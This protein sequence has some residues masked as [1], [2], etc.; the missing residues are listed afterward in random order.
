M[1]Q[2]WNRCSNRQWLSPRPE[3]LYIH[4]CLKAFSTSRSGQPCCC[5]NTFQMLFPLE[6]D[7]QLLS[8][9]VCSGG[10]WGGWSEALTV[11]WKENYHNRA[12]EMSW[13]TNLVLQDDSC[14]VQMSTNVM[15]FF[16]CESENCDAKL[17]IP[18]NRESYR[19]RN[20]CQ[21]THIVMFSTK[22]LFFKLSC[23]CSFNVTGQILFGNFCH[24]GRG[25]VVHLFFIHCNS[26]LSHPLQL[27]T[28]SR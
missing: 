4:S 18:T 21:N 17:I 3:L 23:Q 8:V 25:L 11:E 12:G 10:N 22:L 2:T 19:S 14:L 1:H 24:E 7:Y 15:G 13:P 6:W 20:I 28:D 26:Q 27:P 9:I 16:F 5:D